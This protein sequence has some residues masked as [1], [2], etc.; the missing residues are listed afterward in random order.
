MLDGFTIKGGM[1]SDGQLVFAKMQTQRCR[2]ASK[3]MVAKN[4]ACGLNFV[5]N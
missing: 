4:Q 5:F 1:E 3:K 2:K